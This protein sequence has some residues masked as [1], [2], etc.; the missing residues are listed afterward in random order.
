[1]SLQSYLLVA[2]WITVRDGRLLIHTGKVDIGQR[3][4]TALIQIAHEELT[5]SWDL[6]DIAPVRTGHAP[7]E[8][9]TSGS[10][11]VEQ[12]GHAIRCAAITLRQRLIARAVADKGGDVTDWYASDG[13][14]KRRGTDHHINLLDLIPEIAPDT[15]VDFDCVSEPRATAA[16]PRPKMRGLTDMVR[17]THQYIHDVERP[18]ML[19]ARIIRPPHARAALNDIDVKIVN[20]IKAS[21]FSI[22]RDGCFLAVAGPQEWAVTKAAITLASA[23]E[24]TA[25]DGLPEGDVFTHLTAANAQRFLVLNASPTENP[26]PDPDPDPE[27]SAR[28]ER[29]YQMHGSL[30]PSA[31]LAHWT[32]GLLT[33]NSHSQGIYPLRDSI[34]DSLGLAPTQ[35]DITH[36]PGSGCY[37]HSGADDAAF[38]ACLIA[39]ALPDK[40]ILLKWTRA[41]EHAWEPYASA[42]A[43]DVTAHLEDG[44]ITAYSA[45]VFSD[46][47]RGRP[48]FGPNQAGPSRLL[49]NHFRSEPIGPIAA[50]PTLGRH[51]GMH[52]NLDP[53]YTFPKTRLVKNLVSGLPHRTS[54]MRCLGAAAN[55]F[56]LESFMDELAHRHA[57]SPIAFRQSYLDDP[58]ALAVLAELDRQINTQSNQASGCGR[59][60]AYAQY[61]N[62]MARVGVWVDLAVNDRA[63]IQLKNAI[64]VADAGRVVDADGLSAQLEG[65]FIQAA[66]WTLFEQ[67]KWDR[68]GIRSCDWDSYPV[69]RFDNIPNIE[70]TLLDKPDMPS[71]GAGEASPGPT[72]AAIANAVFDATGLRL[73]RMPFVPDTI[74]KIAAAH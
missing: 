31:A 41:D 15:S 33:V 25:H 68:D 72:I 74:M 71:V 3:I 14:L 58:R 61:K 57:V 48:R 8:G 16:L 47:H 22:I 28:F 30:A 23:C 21:G 42:M 11:S 67:V 19:H 13:I 1:M 20:R 38:E 10:N 60:V 4:S 7:N 17:G 12:S 37:G 29:P 56:A 44:K 40:P 65:G 53:V 45:D 32:D 36:V 39:I 6:I 64:I 24:W 50:Q 73:R 66:S 70:V 62:Q 69:I 35:I 26:I 55:I 63:E 18:G 9:I 5:I 54:A 46:T 34:A 49:S 2:D 27:Y 59:G 52:R 51:A 43:I